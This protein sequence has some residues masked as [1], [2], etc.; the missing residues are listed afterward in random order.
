MAAGIAT[1]PVLGWQQVC[2]DVQSNPPPHGHLSSEAVNKLLKL[3]NVPGAGLA[4]IRRGELVAKFSYGVARVEENQAVTSQTRFQAASLSKTPNAMA[5]L[6]L[7]QQQKQQQNGIRLDDL[8]NRRLKSWQLRWI[9]SNISSDP[10]VTIEM[11]LSHTGG[12]N[13]HGFDGY[14]D[15]NKLPNLMQV[16]N[17]QKPAN[18]PEIRVCC[19]PGRVNLYSGGGITVL[20]QMVI[21]VTGEPDYALFLERQVLTSLQMTESSFDQPPRDTVTN[22]AAFGYYKDGRLLENGFKIYPTIA[23]G[24]LWTTP[25]DYCKILISIMQ[26]YGGESGALLDKDIA[27]NMLNPR[28]DDAALGTFT[29]YNSERN[30]RVFYHS[31][32][33]KG[34]HSRYLGNLKTRNGAVVMTNGDNGDIVCKLLIDAAMQY[35]V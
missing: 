16:L 4:I 3:T 8:V 31:G 15:P 34:F 22:Y 14:E 11:L 7:V 30:E 17:G 10:A 20:Q 25:A 33:H 13:V 18:N 12:T 35:D 1:M 19:L 24:G 5:L 21:D 29:T 2:A 23:A 9:D 28:I 26:S 6:L 32:D 27:I